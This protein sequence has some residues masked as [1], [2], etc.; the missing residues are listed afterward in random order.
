MSEL[1]VCQ[2]GLKELKLYDNQITD[3]SC[4][5]KQ[6]CPNLTWLDL[7][8]NP[9]SQ[10]EVDRIR[11]ELVGCEVTADDL[12]PSPDLKVAPSSDL[13]QNDHGLDKDDDLPPSY[14]EAVMANEDDRGEDLPP[15]YDEAFR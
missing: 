15:T 9:I 11:E 7:S 10:A 8:R 12:L 1:C 14:D 6:S 5:T 13:P 4:I 2:E 3:V